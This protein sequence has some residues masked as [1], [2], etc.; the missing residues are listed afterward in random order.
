MGE[1]GSHR[2]NPG[3]GGP[4]GGVSGRFRASPPQN[5]TF[6]TVS[7]RLESCKR[8]T[9]SDGPGLT[10]GCY[11]G[12]R[13]VRA[14]ARRGDSLLPNWSVRFLVLHHEEAPASVR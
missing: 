14:Q 2:A 8:R 9:D 13:H 12:E 11:V 4:R 3:G 6:G 5:F 10:D 7:G 1:S